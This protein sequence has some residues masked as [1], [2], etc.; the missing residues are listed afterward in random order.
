M[1]LIYLEKCSLAT[2]TNGI[3]SVL[4]KTSWRRDRGV[5]VDPVSAVDGPVVVAEVVHGPV[6]S[7]LVD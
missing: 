3:Y 4:V 5:I 1:T 2:D 6:T 7:V